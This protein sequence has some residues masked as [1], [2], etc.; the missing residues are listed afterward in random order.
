MP[1]SRY[2]RYARRRYARKPYSRSY[3]SRPRT[4]GPAVGTTTAYG[5]TRYFK[6][7][8]NPTQTPTIERLVSSLALASTAGG[9]IYTVINNNPSGYTNFS[10]VQGLFQS[11]RCLAI[12]ITYEPYDPA[13]TVYTHSPLICAMDITGGAALG[14]YTDGIQ[15]ANYVEFNTSKKR[16][17]KWNLVSNTPLSTSWLPTN[18]SAANAYFK[19]WANGLSASRAYGTLFIE[20]VI[21][22][23]DRI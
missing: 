17:W 8:R 6:L 11:Y 19:F 14:S 16:T 15:F 4:S 7:L 12:K 1:Y 21:Q 3:T 10:Q 20:M 13:G 5:T 9:D 18:A 2:R 23:K 22:C